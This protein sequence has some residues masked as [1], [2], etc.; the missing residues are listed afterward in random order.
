MHVLGISAFYHEST[1]CLL[2]DGRLLAAA[3]EERFSRL[4]HDPRLPVAAFRFCLDAGGVDVTDLDAVAYY[5]RP[6]AKLDRQLWALAHA[7][8]AGGLGTPAPPP[9][10][11]PLRLDSGRPERLLRERLGWDGPILTFDHHL[12]HAASAFFY[13]GFPE[14]AVLTV[15]GVGEWATTT[16]GRGTPEGLESFEEVRFPHSLGLLY[17]TVTAYLG[18]R[19]NGGEGKVMGLAAYG[20][21]R[22]A[23]ALRELVSPGPGGGLRLDLAYFDFLAGRRMD[24]PALGDLLGGP[25][26]APEGEIETRHMDVACSLQQVLEETL[27][28]KVRYLHERTGSHHLCLAGGVALNSVANGR[29]AREGPFRELFVQPAAGDAGAAL[30]AAALAHRRLAGREADAIAPLGHVFL[31]PAWSADEVAR[32]VDGAGLAALDY[33]GRE[34]ALLAATAER[35]EAGRVVGWLQGPMELGPRALGGRSLLASPL[36]PGMRDRL[37]LRIKRREVFRPFAPAVL[38]H[39]AGEHFALGHPSP[40]M[41]ETCAVASPLELP[42]IT[43]V[44]GSARPQTVDRATAPRFAALIEAFERRTGCPMLLNTSF[45][46]RGEPVVCSPADALFAL[47]EAG[48]DTLVMEDTL[49]DRESLPAGWAERLGAWRSPPPPPR[50]TAS[51]PGGPLGDNLYTFV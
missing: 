20:R 5:E 9:G 16:Y 11:D 49:V 18:F 4:K 32:L 33:R 19:V 26:R 34:E 13:S 48:F 14:A 7:R 44:D 43:H 47:A 50:G 24:A 38:A 37:N 30:G 23:E 3:S 12:S 46:V 27:L 42:A 25:P 29:I 2:A 40:F 17:S 39:R 1:C 10:I 36:L 28:D 41:L 15:D 8:G 35:L 6:E 31:G 22:Y 45:N 51:D 21:P